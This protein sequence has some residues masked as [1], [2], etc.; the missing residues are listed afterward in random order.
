QIDAGVDTIQLFDSWIGCLSP[1]DY[2]AYV[3]PHNQQILA[4]LRSRDIPLI[5]FGTDTATLLGQIKDDGATVVGVDWRIPL[6]AARRGLG[7]QV[8]IQGNLD[9]AV[10][11]APW[12]VVADRAA[13]VLRQADGQAGHIF[14]LGHGIYPD[15]PV[16]TIA[17]LVDFVHGFAADPHPYAWTNIATT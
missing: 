10:M 11:L 17:R 6:D 5:Y 4:A 3:R 15:T 12:N 2:D 9:P 7:S 8:A 14:N 16:D 1:W 13:D